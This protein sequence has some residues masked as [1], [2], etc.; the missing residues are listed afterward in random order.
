MRTLEID[1]GLMT[2]QEAL[3]LARRW[4]YENPRE[5]YGLK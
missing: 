1:A 4:F 5:L 2:R 3:V